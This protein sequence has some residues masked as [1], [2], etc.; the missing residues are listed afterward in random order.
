MRISK[1]VDVVISVNKISRKSGNETGVQLIA[2]W[3][4]PVD[5]RRYC[6]KNHKMITRRKGDAISIEQLHGLDSVFRKIFKRAQRERL[7]RKKGERL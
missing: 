4:R 2:Y 7:S 6:A 1:E 3:D 5:I